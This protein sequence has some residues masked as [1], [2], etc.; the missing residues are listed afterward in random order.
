MKY[1]IRNKKIN[2]KKNTSINLNNSEI[3]IQKEQTE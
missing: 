2:R 3:N 1:S